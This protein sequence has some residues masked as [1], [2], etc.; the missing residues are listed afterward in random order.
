MR[1]L[2]LLLCFSPCF[3][4]GQTIN[5]SHFALEHNLPARFLM[6]DSKGYIWIG[7][8]GVFRF[9]GITTKR[10]VHDSKNANSL[11]NNV[12][13]NIAEDKD[14]TIWIGTQHGVSHYYP[15]KDS[16]ENFTANDIYKN[17]FNAATDN[18]VFC[19]D[20]GN[21][22][23]GNQTGIY[24][25]NKQTR[26]FKNF[27][28]Q[29][30]QQPNRSGGN[31]ITSIIQDKTNKKFFWFSSFDGIAHFNKV[32]GA[33]QYF[34]PDVNKVLSPKIFQDAHN[35]LWVCTWGKGLAN[36]NPL[37]KQF[38]FHEFEKDTHYG[39]TNVVTDIKEQVINKDS[40][41]FYF[42]SSKGLGVF[43]TSTKTRNFFDSFYVNVSTNKKTIGGDPQSILIDKQ[44][45]VW[46]G[47]TTD[48]SYV[49]HNNQ[50][51]KNYT[52]NFGDVYCIHEEKDQD[53]SAH[54]LIASW[55]MNGLFS[56]DETLTH[57][58][59]PNILN[60]VSKT[61]DSK[62]INTI[63]DDTST[64]TTWIATFDGLFAWYR[65]ANAVKAFRADTV[66]KSSFMSSHI[67]ALA[68]DNN[69][70]LWIGM[71]DKGIAVMNLADNKCIE[72]PAALRNIVQSSY[73][74][75]L[76]SDK[77]GNIWIGIGENLV[78]VN[79]LDLSFKK[80]V[81]QS[82][83][84]NCITQ[85]K[86]NNIWVGCQQGL[87]MLNKKNDF[88]VY[89]IGDGLPNDEIACIDCD[90]LGNLWI[91]TNEGISNMNIEAKT[92]I[93]YFTDDGLTSNSEYNFITNNS[94]GE[95][96]IGGNDFITSFNP[97]ELVTNSTP[98][99]VYI[100]SLHVLNRSSRDTLLHYP[101]GTVHLYYN[102]NYFN[103]NFVAL[104]LINANANRYAYKLEGLDNDWTYTN[105]RTAA[106]YSNLSPGTYTFMVKA[107]NNNN[108][109][110][111]KGA[112]LIIVISPPFW[113][114]WWFIIAC[115]ILTCI[116]I[117]AMYRY[118]LNAALRVE[119][120]RTRIST[121]LHDD[122]GSTLSSISILSDMVMNDSLNG[123]SKEMLHEIKENSVNLMEK[124]DDIVWSINPRNDSLEKLLL[125]IKHFAAQLF[126]AKNID[127]EIDISEHIH[128]FKLPMEI[129]QHL[130][131]MIKEAINNIIKHSACTQANISIKHVHDNLLIKIYD[132]G[133][134]FN[135]N[136]VSYGNG[137]INLK[138]R[139]EAIHANLSVQS[140]NKT[141]GT[142]I[143]IELKIK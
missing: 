95:V 35:N 74:P 24:L 137:L 115:I 51:F 120:L 106:N 84:I 86:Q 129:R 4:Q 109:W 135:T 71:Y 6:Q 114:T 40:S 46:V 83:D 63:L 126:E 82:G 141:E 7:S 80:F 10:F 133:K 17:R 96:L 142:Q 88:D 77:K 56:Y 87:C 139:A 57:L 102:Q 103:V 22:W 58:S 131:L 132:N 61:N 26:K 123:N 101:S 64:N 47:T 25:F 1:N 111:N 70:R 49:L 97:A 33:A 8:D 19:D 59:R 118:R 52:G 16:F 136:K 99:P 72:L 85:D 73:T 140:N 125:R 13:R 76:F 89:T 75:V 62:Q 124:M 14:G 15:A 2:L 55:Y 100:T 116:I 128:S 121:D 42:T 32:T 12:V 54:Y 130:Y 45:T 98:P 39:I 66:N 5:F 127:Y 92:F 113:Q 81:T 29:Q 50:V 28:L 67:I 37:T 69:N 53:K 48:I 105:I 119:R 31:F 18:I 41:V 91:C 34:Y 112:S 143:K 78:Y 44:S 107:A 23:L 93:N 27:P 43:T 3:L 68:K 134:G 122:I 21:V 11:I 65:K 104:N 20:D 117:Y 138:E 60:A 94:K 9:D 110:N 90:A 108:V 38:T 79:A 30:F 36:F